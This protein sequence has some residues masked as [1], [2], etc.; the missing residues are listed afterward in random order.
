MEYKDSSFMIA[1][2]KYNCGYARNDSHTHNDY[3]IIFVSNGSLTIEIEDKVYSAKK[4]DILLITNLESHR[5][6]NATSQ[7]TRY[8]VS[9]RPDVTDKYIRNP[10]LIS[11]LKNHSSNFRHCINLS[12]S[13]EKVR[14]IFNKLLKC[15]PDEE[16]A[17]ELALSYLIEL[18]VIVYRSSE[19]LMEGFEPTRNESILNVQRYLD[20]HYSE[21]IRIA[22]ICKEFCIS[23][24]YLSHKF[25][26][27]TGFSPKQ[28]LTH[29]RLRNAATELCHTKEPIGD[30]AFQCGF[31]DVNS[32]IKT[33]KREFDCLPSTYRKNYSE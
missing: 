7:Y 22:D 1:S 15:S 8:Y 31:H 5:I 23:T 29:L 32:F 6:T 24:C 28:Y 16:F 9:L 4:D 30:I 19:Y 12:A 18:L 27:L 3:E 13:N 25:K 2:S 26:E 10:L 11:L 20:R 33:F 21:D 17:N 14:I